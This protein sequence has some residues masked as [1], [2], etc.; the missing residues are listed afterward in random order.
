MIVAARPRSVLRSPRHDSLD[1][2]RGDCITVGIRSAPF[3]LDSSPPQLRASDEPKRQQRPSDQ[4]RASDNAPVE[5]D[6]RCVCQR[7][8]AGGS[9]DHKDSPRAGPCCRPGVIHGPFLPLERV[10]NDPVQLT[11]LDLVG[12][13]PPLPTMGA[14]KH[15]E[16]HG[17]S[18]QER[19]TTKARPGPRPIEEAPQARHAMI[20]PQRQI[21][22]GFMT[23]KPVQSSDD[24]WN[25]VT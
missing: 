21:P 3:D 18:E 19:P 25:S 11:T 24:R 10:A 14:Q 7:A 2:V 20:M 8:V 5:N 13:E 1:H 9:R 16:Q 4:R 6:V 17:E 15:R 22:S 23:V 12:I